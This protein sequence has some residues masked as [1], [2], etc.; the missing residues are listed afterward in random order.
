MS[1]SP[2]NQL[3]RSSAYLVVIREVIVA[4]DIAQTIAHHEPGAHVIIAATHAQAVTA[5]GPVA[6]LAIAF[7]S[8]RPAQFA[9]SG[10][11]T[12]IAARGGRVVLLGEDAEVTGPNAD[13]SVLY[14]PF[15]TDAVIAKL[16]GG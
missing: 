6:T 1:I 14:Q 4:N 12:A 8:E 10:L 2:T 9:Q 3:S 13:W 16:T 7:I 5:L 11:C 15:T